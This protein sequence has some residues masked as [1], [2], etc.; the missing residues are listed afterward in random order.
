VEWA[1]GWCHDCTQALLWWFS[2]T[3]PDWAVRSWP[4]YDHRAAD[5]GTQ[6]SDGG[7]A[8]QW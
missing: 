5:V 4:F 2:E 8:A 7:T 3:D 6:P 1:V